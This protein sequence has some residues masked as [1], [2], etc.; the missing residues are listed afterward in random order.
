MKLLFLYQQMH[1]LLQ[2]LDLH[3][4]L[5]WVFW[6]GFCMVSTNLL[7]TALLVFF[8]VL[9]ILVLHRVCFLA[10]NKIFVQERSFLKV[11]HVFLDGSTPC[12]AS[13]VYCKSW[14]DFLRLL[15]NPAKVILRFFK[16]SPAV[17]ACGDRWLPPILDASGTENMSE[18]RQNFTCIS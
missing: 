3:N 14:N 7:L 12:T 5:C 17:R 2:W 4:I 10:R 9:A 18:I 8:V 1:L 13:T 15:V 16:F 6:L 11:A